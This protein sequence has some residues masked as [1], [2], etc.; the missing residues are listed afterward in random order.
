M[1][2][3]RHESRKALWSKILLLFGVTVPSAALAVS[4][5]PH[6]GFAGIAAKGTFIAPEPLALVLL[7]SAFIS[8]AVLIRHFQS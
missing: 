4:V 1:A 3:R 2:S 8:L 7:G 6:R 5:T